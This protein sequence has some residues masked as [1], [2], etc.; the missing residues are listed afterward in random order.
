M[1]KYILQDMY[2][3][4]WFYMYACIYVQSHVFPCAR[5]SAWINR[6]IY[7][8]I[9]IHNKR[10]YGSFFFE[11]AFKSQDWYLHVICHVETFGGSGGSCQD[12]NWQIIITNISHT[13][14][15]VNQ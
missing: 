11:F 14:C 7:K 12:H 3:S 9:Y 13:K 1:M 8:Y 10:I 2:V 4:M 15:L 6:Y 5:N